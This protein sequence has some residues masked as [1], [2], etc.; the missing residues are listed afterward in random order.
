MRSL[1]LSG[2]VWRGGK[3]V[4]VDTKP[5]METLIAIFGLFFGC[6][7]GQL[8]RVFTIDGRTYRVCCNCGVKFDYSL[9]NMSIVR[10]LRHSTSHIASLKQSDDL[11]YAHTPK[12]A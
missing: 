4:V 1:Q 5:A 6:K 9:E 12:G 8:S 3:R 7:H 2:G 11:A 10:R